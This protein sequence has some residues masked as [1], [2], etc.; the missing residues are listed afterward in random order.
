[1]F[2][3]CFACCVVDEQNGIVYR[4]TLILNTL[5]CSINLFLGYIICCIGVVAHKAVV[6]NLEETVSAEELGQV[7]T[8]SI[9]SVLIETEQRC[10]TADLRTVNNRYLAQ[11]FEQ[12]GPELGIVSSKV[13]VEPQTVVQMGDSPN[14]VC[15]KVIAIGIERT[16]H[17]LQRA[18]AAIDT[19]CSHTHI[20]NS[21]VRVEVVCYLGLAIEVKDSLMLV[22]NLV[23]RS[24][25]WARFC[26]NF[27]YDATHCIVVV[28]TYAP[29]TAHIT[30]AGTDCCTVVVVVVAV[31]YALAEILI[32]LCLAIDRC[33]AI[34]IY[35]G[36]LTRCSP[37]RIESV[38]LFYVRYAQKTQRCVLGIL[39]AVPRFEHNVYFTGL[40]I[41]VH[42]RIVGIAV[43]A[44]GL[45]TACIAVGSSGNGNVFE[46]PSKGFFYAAIVISNAEVAISAVPG[47]KGKEQCLAMTKQC[48]VS[49]KRR[50]GFVII[51]VG[52]VIHFA[53]K[54]LAAI[55][56]TRYFCRTEVTHCIEETV[57]VS[58]LDVNF[59]R[60]VFGQFMR[61][62]ILNGCTVGIVCVNKIVYP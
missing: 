8:G 20:P 2:Q 58:A 57:D 53:P 4:I 54:V 35:F 13:V 44:E 34:I 15:I 43:V 39:D 24:P 29:A 52:I 23:R 31:I 55:G 61:E 59:Q 47:T 19:R 45:A 40:G 21:H 25:S 7:L 17:A 28:V 60:L 12:A 33:T 51:P 16:E 18:V 30:A 37:A 42:S 41:K 22:T 38:H 50:A 46:M 3:C 1:M 9:A 5:Y 56:I 62:F 11:Q 36:R 49:G 6:H 10:F 48:K 14:V 26:R 27:A 32:G